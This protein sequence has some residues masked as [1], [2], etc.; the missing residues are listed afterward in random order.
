[1]RISTASKGAPRRGRLRQARPLDRFPVVDT[2]DLNLICNAIEQVYVK[3]TLQLEPGAK[4]MDFQLNVCWLPR[5]ALEYVGYGGAVRMDFPD[6]EGFSLKVPLADNGEMQIGSNTIALNRR[7]SGVVSDGVPNKLTFGA[8]YEHL[9]VK[10]QRHTLT[11]KLANMIGAPVQRPLEFEPVDNGGSPGAQHLRNF[12]IYLA[13]QVS[14]VDAPFPDAVLTEL[15]QS[16]LV[17][18]LCGHRHNYSVQLERKPASV[19]PWQVRRAEEYIAAHWN[20]PITI[21]RLAAAANSSARSLFRTFRQSRGMS[22]MAFAKQVRLQNAH[23]LLNRS[24]ATI[25]DVALTCGFSDLS[26]FSKEYKR[27]FGASPSQTR[28]HRGNTPQ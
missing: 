18:L 1:M 26:G 28:R 24:D 25:T 9:L 22:P 11:E 4:T 16:L 8:G 27:V 6:S 7:S 14:A 13:E 21:E 3:P 17:W 5:I 15:E 10:V 2:D 23:K 12:V 20:E 19:A